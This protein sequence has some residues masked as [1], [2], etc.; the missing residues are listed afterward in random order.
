MKPV[1]SEDLERVRTLCTKYRLISGKTVAS[2][3]AA[4]VELRPEVKP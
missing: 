1:D 3:T 4:A 2:K